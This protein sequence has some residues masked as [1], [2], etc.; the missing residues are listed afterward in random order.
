[1]EHSFSPSVVHSRNFFAEGIA[2]ESYFSYVANGYLDMSSDIGTLHP[3][4]RARELL[5]WLSNSA[6]SI[7]NLCNIKIRE[8]ESL[9][10][11]KF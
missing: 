3:D 11:V 6:K 7:M 10:P 1:M 2:G 9:R 5:S 8:V 4:K